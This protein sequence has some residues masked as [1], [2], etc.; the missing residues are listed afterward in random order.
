[1][2][3]PSSMMLSSC[4]QPTP[5]AEL[6]DA[7]LSAEKSTLVDGP[8][9]LSLES[10]KMTDEQLF[11]FPKSAELSAQTFSNAPTPKFSSLQTDGN[12]LSA[13]IGDKSEAIKVSD[14]ANSIAKSK[15]GGKRRGSKRSSK[16]TQKNKAR[17]KR[18]K[19]PVE[20]NDG[21]FE[22]SEI[23]RQIGGSEA[24]EEVVYTVRAHDGD[25][26]KLKVS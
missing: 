1:M 2:E 6:P 22:A 18:N 7:L 25:C 21:A 10:E 16:I 4:L 14:S 9:G 15:R 17:P 11:Q 20:E 8:K 23:L 3:V 19:K 12:V 5:T 26:M 13:H 24:E